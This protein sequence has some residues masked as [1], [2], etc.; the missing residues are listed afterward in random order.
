MAHSTQFH[1]VT[2]ESIN[3]PLKSYTEGKE[4]SI[5]LYFAK[6]HLPEIL[7]HFIF[8]CLNTDISSLQY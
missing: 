8:S 5:Y 4:S 3:P 1:F 2:H 7:E 6:L